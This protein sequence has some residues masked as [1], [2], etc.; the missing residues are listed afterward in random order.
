MI[1]G[2]RVRKYEESH[3]WITFTASLKKAGA[4]LWI[5]LGECQSK[6]EHITN[7][8]IEPAVAEELHKVYLAKGSHST[9]AIEGNT[10]SEEDVRKLLDKK[11][12]LPPSKEYLGIEVENMIGLF[13]QIVDEFKEGKRPEVCVDRIKSING[14]ILQRLELPEEVSPGNI[15]GHNVGVGRYLGAPSKDC[16]FLLDELCKWINGPEF[17]PSP[18]REKV[19]GILKAI[20]AHLYLAW[21]HPFGDGNGRTARMVEFQILIESGCPVPASHLLSSHYNATRTEYYRQLDAASRSKGDIIPFIS[22]S[23]QGFLDGLKSQLKKLQEMELKLTWTN[24]VYR[25]FRERKKTPRNN[26]L[27]ELLLDISKLESSIE[28]IKLYEI[29]SRDVFAEYSKVKA[30]TLFRDLAELHSMKMI[31]WS[32]DHIRARREEILPYL[33]FTVPPNSENNDE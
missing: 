23:V 1:R 12:E 24:F 18:G 21:I 10:L 16:E 14:E 33:P 4:E 2:G 9:T 17:F 6:L 25:R 26:R 22:Y 28:D 29:M 5:M 7:T 30:R 11:L 31:V 15:R 20:I 32:G 19:Y 8:P 13:N 3:P 27:R